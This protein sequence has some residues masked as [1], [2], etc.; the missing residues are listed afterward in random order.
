MKI[1]EGKLNAK[2]LKIAIIVSRFNSFITDKLLAGALDQ[3]VRS[4]ANE[5]DIQ[6]V[7]VPGSF[8]IPLIAKKIAKKGNVDA[9]ICL[10]TI[11][12]GD[13]PHFEY[14][15]AETTKGI[16]QVSLEKEIPVSFGILTTDTLEQAIDRAGTKS[17]NKGADAAISVIELCNL[18]KNI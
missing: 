15:A 8:E 5:A 3:L 16:A 7:K 17:G 18:I 11:I 13:T 2:G 12:R 10:G 14:V 1:I 9:I 6:V 4:Q